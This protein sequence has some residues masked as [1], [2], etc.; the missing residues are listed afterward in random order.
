ML[1]LPG[2]VPVPV[3]RWTAGFNDGSSPIQGG[4]AR[5]VLL[6]RMPYHASG[7]A[8]GFVCVLAEDAGGNVSPGATCATFAV[9][10][11]P[12]PPTTTHTI[13]YHEPTT[14]ADGTPLQGL[15]SMRLPTRRWV[16]RS[17]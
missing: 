7:A 9:P 17:R 15:A 4:V 2:S 5:P 1:D 11:R 8:P 16:D 13:D 12:A 14:K 3:Y 10:A 6:V